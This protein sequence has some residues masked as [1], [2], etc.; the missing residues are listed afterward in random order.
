VIG[1]ARAALARGALRL[2]AAGIGNARLDARVLLAHVVGVASDA[3]FEHAEIE[4]DRI[5]AFDAAIARRALRE[6]LAYITGS[7]EFWSLSFAVGPGV[8]LPRPETETLIEEALRF[9]SDRSAAL[10]V[11]DIGTGS[12]CLLVA[13]LADCESAR[14]LGIDISDAA[15]AYARQ[16]ALRHG[17]SGRSRFL[18]AEWCPPGPETF[19]VV[20]S[21][22]PYL[23]AREFEHAQP[24][25]RHYEPRS[26]LAA[27]SDGLDGM[28]ALAPVL[29]KCLAP[30][31]R[32]FVEAGAGQAGPAAQILAASGLE[33]RRFVPDLSGVPRCLVVGRTG[34]SGS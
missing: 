30:Q 6:P 33:V 26:A 22:P 24:E 32:G 13:I 31:G 19:D 34:E 5:E 28:R 14:G 7:K 8:L 2:R 12:G 3:V 16:N 23:S 15:L 21:N 29:A 25:I 1:S 11:L 4:S 20:L 9:F 10:N 18:N 27:G 17:V